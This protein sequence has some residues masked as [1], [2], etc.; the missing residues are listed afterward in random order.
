[1]GLNINIVVTCLF[2][3]ENIT[4]WSFRKPTCVANET[5]HVGLRKDLY[6]SG[7]ILGLVVKSP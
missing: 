3:S 7:A 1:M 5:P 2:L 4:N 6:G